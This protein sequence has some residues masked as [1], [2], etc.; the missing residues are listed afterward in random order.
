MASFEA[1]A[2]SSDDAAR[3]DS[4]RDDDAKRQPATVS[5][6]EIYTHDQLANKR[7]KKNEPNP[8]LG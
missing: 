4:D 5:S 3:D 1:V 8:Q 6:S 7:K 2:S